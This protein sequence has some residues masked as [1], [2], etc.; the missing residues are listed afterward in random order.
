MKDR[1][2]SAISNSGSGGCAT[3][4]LSAGSGQHNAQIV[5]KILGAAIE[6][7]RFAIEFEG[8]RRLARRPG[9]RSFPNERQ[10]ALGNIKQRVGRL[11]HRRRAQTALL[12]LWLANT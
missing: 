10:G 2:R 7:A 5:V 11:A 6:T 9:F 8:L 1:A 12:C 3:G 4:G